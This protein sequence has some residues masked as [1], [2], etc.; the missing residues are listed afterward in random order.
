MRH[1]ARLVGVIIV[2]IIV[3]AAYRVMHLNISALPEPGPF[4]TSIATTARD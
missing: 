4:E 2:L 1:K 3:A